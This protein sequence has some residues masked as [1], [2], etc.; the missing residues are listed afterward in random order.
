[1]PKIYSP[2]YPVVTEQTIYGIWCLGA[3]LVRNTK[4]EINHIRRISDNRLTSKIVNKDNPLVI[5]AHSKVSV[6]LDQSHLLVGYPSFTFSEGKA[7]TVKITYAEALFK[8]GIKGNRNEI[9]GKDILGNYDIYESDG[10][11]TEFLP[12][13]GCAHYVMYSW[14]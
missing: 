10:A 12:H 8:D 4:E 5:P 3:Y 2:Q 13:C 11:K 14:I 6:L 7:S 9:E 1:M